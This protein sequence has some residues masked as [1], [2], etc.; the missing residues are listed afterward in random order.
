[1]IL[2]N[3]TLTNDATTGDDAILDDQDLT[4]MTDGQDL[5]DGVTTVEQGMTMVSSR[6]HSP[7]L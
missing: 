7:S 1:M 5:T 3:D 4:L 2:D 6:V